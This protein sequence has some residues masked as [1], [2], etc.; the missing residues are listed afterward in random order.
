MGGSHVA[1][2]VRLLSFG[3]DASTICPL[4]A[5]I[6]STPYTID[7]GTT[8]DTASMT[9]PLQADAPQ[10]FSVLGGEGTSDSPQPFWRVYEVLPPFAQLAVVRGSL[11]ALPLAVLCLALDGTGGTGATRGGCLHDAVFDALIFML[12]RDESADHHLRFQ[13]LTALDICLKQ[14]VTRVSLD[15]G[16]C[17]RA[18]MARKQEKVLRV[19]WNS[20]EDPSSGIS[21]QIQALF[22]YLLDVR[23]E[24]VAEPLVFWG[25]LASQFLILDWKRKGKY[26]PLISIASRLGAP[27]LMRL[28][29]AASSNGGGGGQL[30]S[31]VVLA[32]AHSPVA[33]V[34]ASLFEALLLS[35]MGDESGH[36]KKGRKDRKKQASK[37]QQLLPD[38]GNL[39]QSE[40][41]KQAECET[42]IMG[43][44][45]P[46][47]LSALG[48]TNAKVQNGILDHALP[49]FLKTV[50]E[51]LNYLLRALRSTTS[52]ETPQQNRGGKA[53]KQR[54]WA[55]VAV[56]SPS[57]KY[58]DRVFTKNIEM[59][60]FYHTI[61]KFP[62]T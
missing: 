36:N 45:L 54:L 34:A 52:E 22:D 5:D 23:E 51:G 53:T 12:L 46:P 62:D 8:S 48:S 42:V 41:A 27:F 15:G 21:G 33:S 58:R 39:N 4:F 26:K 31:D 16:G 17:D 40:A 7:S 44:I 1:A 14:T 49:T 35:L 57:N 28:Y 3:A 19:V 61:L 6:I 43:T 38:G 18:L 47:L 50:P 9:R 29:S 20:L 59:T 55:L 30:L 60:G 10:L 37:K 56:P 32:L 25:K 2:L 11:S 24:S 13:A